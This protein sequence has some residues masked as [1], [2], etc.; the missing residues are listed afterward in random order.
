MDDRSVL[1]FRGSVSALRH[2]LVSRR[3]S[4]GREA[5]NGILRIRQLVREKNCLVQG[6]SVRLFFNE[7]HV[8]QSV[9]NQDVL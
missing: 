7:R 2:K 6:L 3:I 8:N 5:A 9:Y 1:L 4:P